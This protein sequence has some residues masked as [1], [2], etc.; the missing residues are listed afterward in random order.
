MKEVRDVWLPASGYLPF[1]QQRGVPAGQ[2]KDSLLMSLPGYERRKLRRIERSA[3]KAD[4]GLAARFSIFNR[5]NRYEDM[6]R[7]ERLKRLGFLSNKRM[8][9]TITA[10]FMSGTDT[11][12]P[13]MAA[14]HPCRGEF[15]A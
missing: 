8:G 12:L 10:Y 13:A 2:R 4:P 1:D 15:A 9:R 11:L 6:P 3:A 5:L 7:T 14:H